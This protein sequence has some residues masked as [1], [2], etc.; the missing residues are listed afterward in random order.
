[1]R[2]SRL[3]FR[4]HVGGGGDLEEDF[5]A[6]PEFEIEAAPAELFVFGVL[7]FDGLV[8]GAG[9]RVVL[10]DVF[11]LHAAISSDAE[12]QRAALALEAIG[13]EHGAVFLLSTSLRVAAGV[14]AEAVPS[15]EENSPGLECG[16]P[17]KV[18]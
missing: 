6:L 8:D 17:W 13:E 4:G 9:A 11:G 2:A 7:E 14:N 16:R 15:V 1:M 12:P 18:N 3:V 5:V 10:H